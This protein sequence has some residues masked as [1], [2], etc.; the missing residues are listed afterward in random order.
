LR[1]AKHP[2]IRIAP[3]FD[4]VGVVNQPVEDTL[5]QRAIADLFVPA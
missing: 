1:F 2:W 3:H 4:T 5:G